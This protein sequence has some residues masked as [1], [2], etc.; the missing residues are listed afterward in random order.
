MSNKFY[1]RN[2]LRRDLNIQTTK[3]IK[4]D[5]NYFEPHMLVIVRIILSFNIHNRQISGSG[6]TD[7]MR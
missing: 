7:K 6:I 3:H 4:K 2:P 1:D 5:I